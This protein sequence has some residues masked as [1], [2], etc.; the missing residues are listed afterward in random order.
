[1][2][3]SPDELAAVMAEV[4]RT[5][6]ETPDDALLQS[7]VDVAASSI[8][9][10]DSASLSVLQPGGKETILAATDDLARDLDELQEKLDEGPCVEAMRQVAL[11]RAP[12]L[13]HEQ[14]WASYVA[15]A[16]QRGLRAQIS[17]KVRLDQVGTLGGLNVYS[18]S[19]DDITDEAAAMTELF[20]VQAAV[21]LGGAQQRRHLTQALASRQLI[22]QAVGL[23]M[24]R[25]SLDEHQAFK[26][27]VRMSTTTNTKLNVIAQDL[28]ESANQRQ[29]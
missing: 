18:T 16:V 29:A 21:A 6:H 15:E 7:V 10:F 24:E 1:M 20:A 4:A 23:V 27:L 8:P 12:H 17:V 19:S 5:L 28:V 14:R 26:F 13:R 11:V 9:G 2:A 3:Q 25:Y 22:G